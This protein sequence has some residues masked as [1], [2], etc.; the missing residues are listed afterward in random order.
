[1]RLNKKI[2]KYL[3]EVE[4]KVFIHFMKDT[5]ILFN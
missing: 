5:F 1:M 4:L 3:V 2:F